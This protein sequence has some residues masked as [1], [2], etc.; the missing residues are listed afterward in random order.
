MVVPPVGAVS[1]WHVAPE[2]IPHVPRVSQVSSRTDGEPEAKQLHPRA[3]KKVDI[4]EAARGDDDFWAPFSKPF[5]RRLDHVRG[6]NQFIVFL[7]YRKRNVAKR[8]LVLLLYRLL[9][10]F[11]LASKRHPVYVD[12]VRNYFHDCDSCEQAGPRAW[13]LS[14]I[15]ISLSR[16]KPWGHHFFFIFKQQDLLQE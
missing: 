10:R 15:S 6:M 11:L 8:K 1:N 5:R 16:T 9:Q 12:F 2:A 14:R 13:S 4:D 7:R 3:E